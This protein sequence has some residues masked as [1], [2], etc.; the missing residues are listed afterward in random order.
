MLLNTERCRELVEYQSDSLSFRVLLCID[1]C[2]TIISEKDALFPF[3]KG[4]CIF[5][6]ADSVKIRL[7]G[8]AQFLD[9]RG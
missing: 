7:H 2:G 5:V 9:V 4:D 6:P 1:G 3:F 8:R